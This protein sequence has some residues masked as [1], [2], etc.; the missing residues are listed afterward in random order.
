[1]F[2]HLNAVVYFGNP[3]GRIVEVVTES[4][5]RGNNLASQVD[6]ANSGLHFAKV[7]LLV[8]KSNEM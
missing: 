2:C 6:Q 5:F 3:N 1:M 7:D 8:F 4:S